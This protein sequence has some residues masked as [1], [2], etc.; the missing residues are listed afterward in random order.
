[1]VVVRVIGGVLRGVEV[2]WGEGALRVGRFGCADVG[3]QVERV[4]VVRSARGL[5]AGRMK[6]GVGR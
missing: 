2:A 4:E 1:V 5:G 6:R 3:A